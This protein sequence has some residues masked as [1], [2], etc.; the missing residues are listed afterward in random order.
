LKGFLHKTHLDAEEEKPEEKLE[1]PCKVKELNYFDHIPIV[2]VKKDL[3]KSA[4]M[5]YH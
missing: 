4:K 3:T 5:N 1:V 2:T